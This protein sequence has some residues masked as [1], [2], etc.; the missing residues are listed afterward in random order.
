MEKDLLSW[1]VQQAP[2]VVVLGIAIYFLYQQMKQKDTEIK[3]LN[4]EIKELNI[5]IRDKTMDMLVTLRDVSVVIDKVTEG[6]DHI[7]AEVREMQNN[8]L[9]RIDKLELDG[10]KYGSGKS[11]S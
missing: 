4:N 2:V 10:L 9:A 8:I 5:Y 1:L 11:K 6:Q 7:S 3:G